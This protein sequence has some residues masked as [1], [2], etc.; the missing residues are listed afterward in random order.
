MSK[1]RIA[2]D[3]SGGDFAPQ[4]VIEALKK[5]SIND[6][7]TYTIFC[8][9]EH[10][11]CYENAQI[12]AQI[13][14]NPLQT[15]IQSVKEKAHLACVSAGNTIFYVIEALR[16]L[17]KIDGIKR[18]ALVTSSPS[19]P[20][21]KILVDLGANLT[22]SDQDLAIF[23]IMGSVYAKIIG[24][25]DH[26]KVSFLN[27]GSESIKGPI[28]IRQARQLYNQTFRDNADFIESD[29][30]FSKNCDVVVMDGYS[31]NILIKFAAGL[32]RFF[33]KSAKEVAHK[34]LL[35]KIRGFIA[36]PLFKQLSSLKADK[37]NTALL[38]GVK[39][40]VIKAH[41]N[42]NASA[43]AASVMYAVDIC[44]HQENIE[45]EVEKKAQLFNTISKDNNTAMNAS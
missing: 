20:K 2:I 43:F 12:E 21:D 11:K 4:C 42:S 24:K 26:P 8:T 18:P 5:I 41:G 19:Y 30:L 6:Q 40:A 1:I 7:I 23:A 3:G 25:I 17:D 35:N 15:I 39:G 45:R 36:K 13:C 29:E 16:N 10:A 32:S 44:L 31:G 9:P 27:I 22:C 28:Y 33:F 38:M 37:H 34:N 14:D